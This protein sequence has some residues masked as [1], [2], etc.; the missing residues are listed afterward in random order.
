M[1]GRIFRRETPAGVFLQAEQAMGTVKAFDSKQRTA[2]VVA[3]TKR[4]DFYG[5]T[6]DPHGW[7]T[8]AY[9]G[10]VLIDH[11]YRIASIVGRSTRQW[12]DGERSDAC[13]TGCPHSFLMEHTFNPDGDAAADMLVPK[14]A[15]R[16]ARANSVGFKPVTWSRVYEEE[17]F[18]GF[19]F[20]THRLLEDSWVAVGANPDALSQESI[21]PESSPDDQSAQLAAQ[22]ERLQRVNERLMA[23]NI[24]GRM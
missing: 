22:Y 17:N 7:L 12:V 1:A 18:V 23:T 20:E 15:T 8:D 5:D 16:S 21:G 3:S 4:R 9:N 13:E 19:A 10:V 11:D 24:L 6:I 14:I 2:T